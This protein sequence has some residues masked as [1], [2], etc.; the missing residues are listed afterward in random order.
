M[1]PFKVEQIKKINTDVL[2]IILT[3]IEQRGP[4][5]RRDLISTAAR[6]GINERAVVRALM[7]PLIR[8]IRGG[9]NKPFVYTLSDEVLRTNNTTVAL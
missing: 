2:R 3:S 8:L 6:D 9:Y 4:L 5:S 7:S 1:S